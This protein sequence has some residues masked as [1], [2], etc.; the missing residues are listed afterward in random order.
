MR[1]ILMFAEPDEIASPVGMRITGNYDVVVN[2]VFVQGLES[3]VA[4]CEIAIPSIIIEGV[5]VTVGLRFIESREDYRNLASQGVMIP[6]DLP[7]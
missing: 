2:M 4:I 7:V 5:N 6:R 3:S 1:I